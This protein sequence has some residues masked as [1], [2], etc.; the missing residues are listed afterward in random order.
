MLFQK[1]IQKDSSKDMD[2][3]KTST[4]VFIGSWHYGKPNLLPNKNGDI[5]LVHRYSFGPVETWEWGIDKDGSYYEDYK[6]LEND[7]YEEENYREIITKEQMLKVIDDFQK[8]F[9]SH[10]LKEY[11][12][13][14]DI[15]VKY[16]NER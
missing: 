4:G 3:K 11:V 14:Y 9:N 10:K 7:L 16:I 5:V 12:K 2:V 1:L 8:M 6:W 13:E 15:V